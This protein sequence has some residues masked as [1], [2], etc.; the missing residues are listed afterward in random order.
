MK[1]I[2]ILVNSYFNF[3]N[4]R[5]HLAKKFISLGY[6]V[7]V[8][9]PVTDADAIINLEGLAFYHINL[10]PTSKSL[11]GNIK[12]LRD[13]M[14]KLRR[15]KPDVLLTFTLKPNIYGGVFSL[16]SP[17]TQFL[18]TITGL[19]SFL[20]TERKILKFRLLLLSFL[21]RS[22]DTIYVQNIDDKL[23]FTNFI[24]NS[25]RI[26]VVNGS[27]INVGSYL[28]RD[29]RQ[30]IKNVLYLGRLIRDKGIEKFLTAALMLVSENDYFNFT[31]IGKLDETDSRSPN[32]ELYKKYIEKKNCWHF[33]H[34]NNIT[35]ELRKYDLLI[36]PSLREGCSRVVLE[37]CSANLLV[38]AN[39]VPGCNTIIN[40]ESGFL[41]T[42]SS[43]DV[44][45]DF[46]FEIRSTPHD[47]I[48][49]KIDRSARIV[50]NNFSEVKVQET[51]L[52]DIE[53]EQ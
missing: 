29:V 12:S 35:E 38:A 5:L 34:M 49:R 30:P 19:G 16:T 4:F 42:E 20:V 25:K 46:L 45:A 1:H 36:L 8:L 41:F 7:S 44:I 40:S 51:Y 48:K 37:A 17:K 32:I 2:V 3:M 24:L 26:K 13:V 18:P 22:A 28:Q 52:R 27:G 15:I 14:A 47:I 6:K 53:R 33:D 21:L 9:T 31:V 23:I 50:A 39:D 43:A 11:L 10:H